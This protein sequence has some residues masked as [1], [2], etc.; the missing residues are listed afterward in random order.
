MRAR[1][2]RWVLCIALLALIGSLFALRRLHADTSLE[3]LFAN[4]NRAATAMVRVLNGY[5]AAAE[6][7]VLASTSG[8]D[9]APAQLQQFAGDLQAAIANDPETS[10]L[11]GSVI[12]RTDA[13]SQD[14]FENVV[15]PHGLFYL[16]DQS[17]A[18]AKHRL[19]KEEIFQQVRQDHAMLATP[20]PAAQQLA[21]LILLDPLRLHEFILNRLNTLRPFKTYQNSSA[22]L[23]PDGRSIL[24]RI[25]GKK[26]VSDLQFSR[27]FS[28][29]I[30]RV[31]NAVNRNHLELNFTGS[32]AIAAVSQAAIRSDVISSV[33]G[34]VIFLQLLFVFAYRKPIGSFALAL[35]P[36]ALG[37]VLGLAAYS[38]L[39]TTFTPVAAAIGGILAG[40]GIDYS[41][42]FL[43]HFQHR[44]ME[45]GDAASAAL[46]TLRSLWPALLAA[47]V[48]SLMGFAAIGAA[49]VRALRDF[50]LL[51]SL[52][53]TGAFAAAM[54][55]LPAIVALIGKKKSSV[56]DMRGFIASSGILHWI[57]GQRRI[58]FT[59]GVILCAIAGAIF[60]MHGKSFSLDP[61]LAALNP[62]PNPP[63]DAEKIVQERM[64][65]SPQGMICYLEADSQE[66]LVSLAHR[67]GQRIRGLPGISGTFGL[68]SLLP[69]PAVAKRRIDHLD[70]HLADE[71]L[72]NLR[73]ALQENGFRFEA[74]AG[75]ASFL[76]SLIT[77][78][79]PPDLQALQKYPSLAETILPMD[80][81]RQVREHFDAVTYIFTDAHSGDVIESVR[82]ALADTPGA[83]LTGLGVLSHDAEANA[84]RQFPRL[85]LVA[86][87]ANV[88]YLLIYFRNVHDL[89]L[90]FLPTVVSLG[91]IL[92][93]VSLS[94]LRL[95]IIN[96]VAFPLLL[97]IDVDYGVF[98]VAAARRKRRKI[99]S[100]DEL[101]Q[102]LSPSFS[103]V[104]LCAS[105]TIL[106]F[107][108]LLFTS[109][110]AI[111]ALGLLVSIG[112]LACVAAIA[113]ICVPL[114]GMG[115]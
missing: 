98:L 58:L 49:N 111:H 90:S 97:G 16:D 65:T 73:A 22:F 93:F 21:K 28:A 80:V 83:T 105:A 29:A 54:T 19:T 76:Q 109:I 61:D 41:I 78:R 26:P 71:V 9:A 42:Q 57:A 3:A 77:D 23:S 104:L 14:F 7:I 60:I 75:Y 79:H 50:S 38:L 51:G 46:K 55:I 44:Q 11:A 91:C 114:M 94:G 1:W 18:A 101:M 45:N 89:V 67:A 48:T 115:W 63:L 10:R 106:G 13:Q 4:N 88:L 56:G 37:I 87:I 70:P 2:P 110:P 107:G 27:D 86:L 85:I 12:W 92:I 40:M 103:A 102:S 33:V 112:I 99:M 5:R 96:L 108:S 95:N 25:Q 100:Q 81:S 47:W 17:F 64:G 39:K 8:K 53:L 6:L 74:F 66:E 43:A 68:D 36:I 82:T 59:A 34:S 35:V 84:G 72:A 31:A 69:D 15:V 20:G 113:L 24:I 52:G 30:M 32:Y 62:Q